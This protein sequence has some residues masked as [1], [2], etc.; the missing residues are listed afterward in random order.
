MKTSNENLNIDVDQRLKSSCITNFSKL[1]QKK[2]KRN[3]KRNELNILIP[4]IKGFEIL[5][6]Q[7]ALQRAKNQNNTF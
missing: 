7:D 2:M 6:K 3:E 1:H 4:G 5:I